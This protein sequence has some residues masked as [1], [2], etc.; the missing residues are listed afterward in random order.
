MKKNLTSLKWIWK[1]G[2]QQTVRFTLLGHFTLPL[3]YAAAMVKLHCM[4][5]LPKIA[6]TSNCSHC[7]NSL[8]IN[9]CAVHLLQIILHW[10]EW[11]RLI[12]W[13]TLVHGI[14]RSRCEKHSQQL[15][16]LNT[17]LILNSYVSLQ[18]ETNFQFFRS[19]KHWVFYYH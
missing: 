13:N 9:S 4:H 8:I 10:M 12:M 17:L 5:T 11:K 7:S 2:F 15:K 16:F 14:R 19:K 3:I 1:N 18:R 6:L